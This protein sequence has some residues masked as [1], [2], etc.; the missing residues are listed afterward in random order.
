LNS[1]SQSTNPTN[2]AA[3]MDQATISGVPPQH[4]LTSANGN[5]EVIFHWT[6][7]RYQHL[8]RFQNGEVFKSIEGTPDED[9]P[10]SPALQQ[11]S[12]ESI[13][14]SDTI[15]G[16]GC[17]GTSHFSVSVQLERLEG[18]RFG[19]RFEWAV[20]LSAAGRNE[21]ATPL[22]SQLGS[23]YQCGAMERDQ[24]ARQFQSMDSTDSHVESEPSDRPAVKSKISTQVKLFPMDQIGQRTIV[25]TYLIA[26]PS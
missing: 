10:P 23:T 24:I 9:W 25:W 21:L 13:N 8:V 7:D 5:I 16:V 11:L 19:V 15:L 17:S 4:S 12:T 2:N 22:S 6:G 1:E 3:I 20:R 14:A 26:P 18:D